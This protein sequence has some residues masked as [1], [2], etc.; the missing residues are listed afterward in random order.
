MC[1]LLV[2]FQDTPGPR[3][4]KKWDVIDVR[5]DSVEWGN[6]EGYPT[7]LR[8]KLEGVTKEEA[9]FLMDR[10]WDPAFGYDKEDPSQGNKPLYSRAYRILESR[11]N[12]PIL[13]AIEAA[14]MVSGEYVVTDGQG[15]L[16]WLEKKLD[17][18]TPPAWGRQA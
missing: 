1:R 11:L 7:Y 15:V 5:D 12:P 13:S 8:V 10:E 17:G 9:L 18:S 2:R 4:T 3:G 16:A 14:W 6:L